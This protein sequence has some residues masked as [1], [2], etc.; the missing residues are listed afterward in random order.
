MSKSSEHKPSPWNR[1]PAVD[2]FQKAWTA[3]LDEDGL[4]DLRVALGGLSPVDEPDGEKL[5]WF[6]IWLEENMIPPWAIIRYVYE[7]ARRSALDDARVIHSFAVSA[8][9]YVEYVSADDRPH[10]RLEAV[11][12]AEEAVRVAPNDPDAHYVL[13]L[14]SYEVGTPPGQFAEEEFRRAVELRSGFAA[15]RFYL[16]C[17]LFD[18]GAYS[19]ALAQLTAVDDEQLSRE[20][21]PAQTWRIGRRRELAA[22]CLFALRRPEEAL[23]AVE[24]Y[25]GFVQ[26]AEAGEIEPPERLAALTSQMPEPLAL[27]VRS[28]CRRTP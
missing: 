21:G 13:G 14:A 20:L 8:L 7:E 22:V 4:P 27:R 25:L 26:Q 3:R 28:M 17:A 16:A 24:A 10:L 5:R 2:A 18:R 19:D 11:R 12:L 9:N 15:A 23:R 6:A 1:P